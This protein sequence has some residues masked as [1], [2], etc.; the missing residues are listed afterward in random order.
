MSTG[1][2]AELADVPLGKRCEEGAGRNQTRDPI[3][4][5]RMMVL[6]CHPIFAL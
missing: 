3:Q 4:L 5:D 1:P 2:N 6:T